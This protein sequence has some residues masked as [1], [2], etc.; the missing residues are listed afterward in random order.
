[1][2]FFKDSCAEARAMVRQ[3]LW[4]TRVVWREYK[5]DSGGNL[6]GLLAKLNT[7]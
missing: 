4:R 6:L 2:E 5:K 3:D 7:S 1:M